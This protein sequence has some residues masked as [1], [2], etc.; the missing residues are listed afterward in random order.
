PGAERG[1]HRL[2]ATGRSGRRRGRLLPLADDQPV[3]LVA[4][5]LRGHERPRPVELLA[6]QPDGQT[7]VLL[8]LDQLVRSVVPDLDRAGAVVALRDLALEGRIV[9][10][11]VLDVD[12]EVQ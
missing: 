8:L 4:G 1:K 12:G 7:A 11:M 3:L 6:V 9:E 2:V 5:E 10:R